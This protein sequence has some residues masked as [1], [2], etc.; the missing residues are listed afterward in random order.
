[1]TYIK[2][3]G[4]GAIVACFIVLL[5]SPKPSSMK[6]CA[7]VWEDWH[8]IVVTNAP[9][10]ANGNDLLLGWIEAQDAWGKTHESE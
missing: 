10:E 3:V 6:R 1:M 4:I 9:C 7:L 8:E 2:G 5:L